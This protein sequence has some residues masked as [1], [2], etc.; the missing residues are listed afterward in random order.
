M[1]NLHPKCWAELN[2]LINVSFCFLKLILVT[3]QAK[4]SNISSSRILKCEYFLLFYDLY[5]GN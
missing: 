4:L 1:R 5:H 3:F 2:Q